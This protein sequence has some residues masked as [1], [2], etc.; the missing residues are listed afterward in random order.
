MLESLG[1]AKSLQDNFSLAD[2][3][4]LLDQTLQDH[5]LEIRAQKLA[6]SIAERC[7]RSLELIMGYCTDWAK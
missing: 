7:W 5:Q 2:G 6:V 3:R 1:V 4:A